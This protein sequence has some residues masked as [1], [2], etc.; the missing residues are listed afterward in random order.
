MET[1]IRF[2][3]VMEMYSERKFIAGLSQVKYRSEGGKLEQMCDHV[4]NLYILIK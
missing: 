2:N 1:E 4:S 3:R